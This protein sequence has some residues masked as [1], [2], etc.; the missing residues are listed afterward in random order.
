[1]NAL[2]VGAF[3]VLLAATVGAAVAGATHVVDQRLALVALVS[4][5]A[6]T[7]AVLERVIPLDPDWNRPRRDVAADVAYTAVNGAIHPLL[8]AG[9]QLGC[10]ALVPMIGT[11][12]VWPGHWPLWAQG[13]LA[14]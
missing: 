6:V 7:V 5:V 11:A 1:M 14:L 10:A 8:S 3:P 9:M 2:R 12:S 13:V 4:F